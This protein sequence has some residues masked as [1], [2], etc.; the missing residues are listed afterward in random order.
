MVRD[1]YLLDLLHVEM[2]NFFYLGAYMKRHIEKLFLV[3]FFVISGC[4]TTDVANNKDVSVTPI[5][6][7]PQKLL[8][9]NLMAK[10]CGPHKNIADAGYPHGRADVDF[11][12]GG[13]LDYCRVVTY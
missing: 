7:S 4:T 1:A 3:I 5:A 11:D 8:N 6:T 9:I 13:C 10:L 2:A 12:G